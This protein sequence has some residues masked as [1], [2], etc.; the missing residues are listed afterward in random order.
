MESDGREQPL[1]GYTN[2]DIDNVSIST[3]AKWDAIRENGKYAMVRLKEGQVIPLRNY[4]NMEKITLYR[5]YP[6]VISV[7]VP[8]YMY[9]HS[10]RSK[11]REFENVMSF[12][13]NKGSR[14]YFV[15]PGFVDKEIHHEDLTLADKRNTTETLTLNLWE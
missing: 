8:T 1:F 9:G 7:M 5:E 6:F 2:I 4:L 11:A 10:A 15:D 12:L 14:E 13:G 3:R